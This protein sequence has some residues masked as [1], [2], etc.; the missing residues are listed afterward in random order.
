M[1][2]RG[3][4][5]TKGL[6]CNMDSIAELGSNTVMGVQPLGMANLWIA[7]DIWKKKKTFY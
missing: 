6:S 2:Q 4:R 3:Y 1:M 5:E 7:Q